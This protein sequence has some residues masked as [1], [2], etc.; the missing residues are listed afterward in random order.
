MTLTEIETA[1]NEAEAQIRRVDHMAGRLA[2]LLKGRLR[3]VQ[4]T[5]DLCELKKELR[6]FNIH[7]GRWVE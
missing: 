6:K 2:S 7:T 1:L 4:W 5:N 3:K